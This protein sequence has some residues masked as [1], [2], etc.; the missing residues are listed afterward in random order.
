MLFKKFVGSQ[1]KILDIYDDNFA[2]DFSIVEIDR[3]KE[4]N[5]E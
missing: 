1:F 3:T 4:K 2:V 5:K